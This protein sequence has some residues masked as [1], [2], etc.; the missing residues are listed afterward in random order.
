MKISIRKL[1]KQLKRDLDSSCCIGLYSIR[2]FQPWYNKAYWQLLGEEN[3]EGWD[4]KI[5]TKT[6]K[7]LINDYKKVTIEEF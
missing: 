1:F 6:F 2:W 4:A 5:T 7:Q 3:G